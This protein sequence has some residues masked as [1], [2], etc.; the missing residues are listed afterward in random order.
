[1]Y[2]SKFQI[3]FVKTKNSVISLFSFWKSAVCTSLS[4]TS[5]IYLSK[6]Q[7]AFVQIALC[8][9]FKLFLWKLKT[10]WYVCFLLGSLHCV[11]LLHPVKLPQSWLGTKPLFYFSPRHLFPHFHLKRILRKYWNWIHIFV[12]QCNFLRNRAKTSVTHFKRKINP[13]NPRVLVIFARISI[14][15]KSFNQ[16]YGF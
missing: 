3:V 11:N 6:F 14:P 4:L 5:Q 12:W 9:N 7:N 1:M 16:K 15:W 13:L 10:A 2:L 8:S